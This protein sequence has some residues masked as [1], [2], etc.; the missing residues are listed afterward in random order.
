VKLSVTES[1]A[2]ATRRWV[3]FGIYS[4]LFYGAAAPGWIAGLLVLF[5]S[6]NFC[7]CTRHAL[8][9]CLAAGLQVPLWTANEQRLGVLDD[10]SSTAPDNVGVLVKVV[11]GS[12]AASIAMFP[13]CI[14]HGLA[15]LLPFAVLGGLAAIALPNPS[16]LEN[17]RNQA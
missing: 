8:V 15:R 16:L 1:M 3:P 7:D 2:V 9:T 17:L 12:T 5:V 14:Q 10:P 6:R 4:T 13:H 11:C